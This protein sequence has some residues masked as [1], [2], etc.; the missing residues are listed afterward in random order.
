MG[1][2]NDSHG[3]IKKKT[4]KCRKYKKEKKERQRLEC[5]T[6]MNIFLIE[7]YQGMKNVGECC[8]SLIDEWI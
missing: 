7:K 4:R 5:L 8:E 1:T 2:D 3:F 6:I